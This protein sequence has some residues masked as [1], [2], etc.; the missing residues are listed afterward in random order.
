[1]M[2][3]RSAILRV[4]SRMR[5]VLAALFAHLVEVEV[6]GQQAGVEHE[7]EAV[8][9]A[10]LA[11]LGEVLQRHRLAADQV[12]AG[13]HAHERDLVGAVLLDDG[14]ELG[15]VHVALERQVAGDLQP[16]VG[17]QLLDHAALQRDVRLGGGEVVVHRHDRARL[18]QHL[19]QDV[20]AGAALV[21]RQEVVHAEDLAQLVVKARVGGAAG[22]GVVGDH[23]RGELLVAHGVDAAVGQHVEEHV[24]VLQQEGVVAG[25]GHRLE[26]LFD[27]QQVQLLDDAHLVHFQRDRLVAV[28]L[29]LSPCLST[30]GACQSIVLSA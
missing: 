1:M 5:E 28:E 23:H 8:L 7:Q 22:V 24:G 18:H 2:S 26:A 4:I 25:L 19:G 12:G 10:D 11:D 9:R 21:G 17:D 27:R 6:V 3:H 14:F 13:L 30:P 16:G 15:D 20:L 29:H